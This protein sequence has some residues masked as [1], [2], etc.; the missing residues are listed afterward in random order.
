MLNMPLDSV[1][2]RIY[3]YHNS[4]KEPIDGCNVYKEETDEEPK[5][6]VLPFETATISINHKD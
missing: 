1:K 3:K 4:D 2:D 6:Y 5:I